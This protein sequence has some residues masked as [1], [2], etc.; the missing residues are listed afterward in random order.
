[1]TAQKLAPRAMNILFLE[2]HAPFA[3]VV[4]SEFLSAHEVTVVP[5]LATARGL[6]ASCHFD[7]IISDYD[8]DD[9]K[10]DE[11]VRECRFTHPATPVI[12]ASSHEPGNAALMTAGAVAIC[13]KMTFNCIQEVIESL[14]S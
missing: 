6:I 13:S 9:G 7:L 12:A 2:N 11:F 10:G 4:I 14:K 8:L 5:S 1:M 3:R